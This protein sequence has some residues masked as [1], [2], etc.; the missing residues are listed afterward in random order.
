MEKRGVEKPKAACPKGATA[1]GAWC[2]APR[3]GRRSRRAAVFTRVPDMAA[4]RQRE[5]GA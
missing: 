3:L 2:V 4:V 5:V 1:G